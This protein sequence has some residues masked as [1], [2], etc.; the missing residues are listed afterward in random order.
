M[1][2]G[3]TCLRRRMPRRRCRLL[4]FLPE[5]ILFPV[6]DEQGG[7]VRA[8]AKGRYVGMF[9]ELWVGVHVRVSIMP[10][11]GG[12]IGYASAGK[13]RFSR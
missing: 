6:R 8:L 10:W 5:R 1:A 12:G 4:E 3:M 7:V 13:A 2:M 11:R 9:R